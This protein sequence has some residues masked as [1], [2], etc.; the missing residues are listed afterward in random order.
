MP[1]SPASMRI[2]AAKQSRLMRYR[3][4]L[5]GV[6]EV[7]LLDPPPNSTHVPFRATIYASRSKELMAFLDQEGVE[8]RT[9]FYPLHMQP[10]LA[11]LPEVAA[12]NARS[13]PNSIYAY[14]NGICLPLYPTLP[15]DELDYVCNTIR[16]FYGR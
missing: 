15:F 1:S 4:M 14:E 7:R 11:G 13:F 12:A 8:V 9:F 16:R 5:E 10:A 6:S 2:I 3:A